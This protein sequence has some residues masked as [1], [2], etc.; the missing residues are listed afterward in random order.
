MNFIQFRWYRLTLW[1]MDYM[2]VKKISTPLL[3]SVSRLLQYQKLT[4]LLKYALIFQWFTNCQ[5]KYVV[6]TR[7]MCKV[8]VVISTKQQCSLINYMHCVNLLLVTGVQCLAVFVIW[9]FW[10]MHTAVYDV[11]EHCY[12]YMYITITGSIKLKAGRLTIQLKEIGK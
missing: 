1:L 11:C 10:K 7:S 12:M 9:T 8:I 6:Y 5:Y 2:Y 3:S 4:W